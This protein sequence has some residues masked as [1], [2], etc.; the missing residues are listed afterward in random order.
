MGSTAAV[1]PFSTF[2]GSARWWCFGPGFALI[3]SAG[4]EAGP[5]FGKIGLLATLMLEMLEGLMIASTLESLPIGNEIR[6]P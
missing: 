5:E 6:L 4:D 3:A 1:F 2:F